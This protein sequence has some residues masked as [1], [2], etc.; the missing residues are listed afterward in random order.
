M[1]PVSVFDGWETKIE[2]R[3][4]DG[5]GGFCAVGWLDNRNPWET[6]KV[7][8]RLG[9]WIVANLDPPGWVAQSPSF[10]AVIWANNEK[11]LDIEGFRLVDLLTQGYV[12]DDA[13]VEAVERVG[14]AS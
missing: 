7:C 2:S 3:L 1:R 5:L 9:A 11:K 6:A 4:S 8:R 12:P 14:V 13:E 10:E